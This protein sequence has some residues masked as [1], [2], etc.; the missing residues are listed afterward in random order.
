LHASILERFV[1]QLVDGLILAVVGTF[2]MIPLGI[3]AI[4][5]NP[6]GFF[7]AGYGALIWLFWLLVPL[8]YFSYFES[9]SGQSVGKS[10]MSIRVVDVATGA[11]I[12][13]ARALIR[14]ILRIVDFLPFLYIVGAIIIVA[15]PGHQRLGDLAANTIVVRTHN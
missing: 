4:L 5:A 8:L 3:A 12:D 15:T 10:L 6:L 9:T 1:A 7:F 14:N 2:L 13:F 11:R